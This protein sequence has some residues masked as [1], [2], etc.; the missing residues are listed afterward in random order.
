[1][2]ATKV[3]IAELSKR[4]KICFR[5]WEKIVIFNDVPGKPDHHAGL[6]PVF[7]PHAKL[8]KNKTVSLSFLRVTRGLALL[9]PF[10][11]EKECHAL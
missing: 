4:I 7:G 11:L 3:L 10:L 5:E 8:S 1:M 2:Y 6:L 9:E